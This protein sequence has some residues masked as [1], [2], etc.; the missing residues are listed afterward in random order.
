MKDI[1]LQGK[2]WGFVV[3]DVVVVAV[4]AIIPGVLV[5]VAAIMKMRRVHSDMN[6]R[7]DEW[8][9]LIKTSAFAAGRK[10]ESDERENSAGMRRRQPEEG[11]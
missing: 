2:V 9:E 10:A 6:S 5:G 8:R 11:E 7:F 4:V 1:D 3:S